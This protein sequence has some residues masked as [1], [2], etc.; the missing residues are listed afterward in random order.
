MVIEVEEQKSEE[1]DKQ[2][3]V[4]QMPSPTDEKHQ[5]EIENLKW[6]IKYEKELYEEM[7][8]LL[9]NKVSNLMATVTTLNKEIEKLNGTIQELNNDKTDLNKSIESLEDKIK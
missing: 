4:S 7:S 2:S 8:Q 9:E 6:Q 3:E 1:V 5:I